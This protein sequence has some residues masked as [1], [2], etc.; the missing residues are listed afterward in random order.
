V[1]TPSQRPRAALLGAG[2]IGMLLEEDPKR[3]KPATHLGMWLD[4]PRADLVAVCDR[5]PAKL[6]VAGRLAPGV[7][8]YAD[9]EELL[10]VERPDVISIA[11]WKDSHYELLKLAMA[12]GVRVIVCEKPI[13]E[14]LEHAREVVA[15]AAERGVALLINHRRRFDSLLHTVRE[16][17][18]AGLIGDVLAASSYYVYG[19]LTTGT[20]LVDTLRFLLVDVAGEV[21]WASGFANA[22]PHFAPPD[23]P[24]V[25]AV[26]GFESGLKATVQS[27]DMKR[28]DHFHFELFGTEGKLVLKNIGRDVEVFRIVE[29]PEHEGFTELADTPAERRGGAPRNQFRALA[30]NA[31]DC[32]AGT[33]TSLSTGEDSL[34]AL[35][36][37]LAIRESAASGGAPVA[38]LPANV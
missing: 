22:L 30:E 2:R 9:P 5:D 28:Y 4:T 14:E 31:L 25:D 15:E 18:R 35:E 13:A 8:I 20:H 27:L 24:C 23:D 32:L 26:L 38:V 34:R 10:R 33:A 6:E 7:T 1:S 17:L 36:I 19:L 11:T 16:E 37:L 3:L 12:G 29:S 21:T